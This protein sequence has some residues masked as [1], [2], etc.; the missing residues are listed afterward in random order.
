MDT[1]LFSLTDDVV[2]FIGPQGE[3][4][5]TGFTWLDD[6][7]L[8]IAF[9]PQRHLGL[10]EFVLAPSVSDTYGNA[11][12]QDRDGIVGEPVEDCYRATIRT[13]WAGSLTADTT[14]GPEDGVAVVAG[15]CTIPTGGDP[16]H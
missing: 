13:T 16:D 7:T 4:T 3:V 6:K 5:P 14:W 2:S 8:E 10:Y 9:A 1:T 11:L 12:D 15:T